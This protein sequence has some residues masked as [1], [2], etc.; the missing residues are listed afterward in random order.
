MASDTDEQNGKGIDRRRFLVAA[1]VA[2]IAAA[3]AG[4]GTASA[5]SNV[6]PGETL[7][8]NSKSGK[9]VAIVT[10]TQLNIG[11]PLARKFAQLNYNLVIADVLQGLPEELRKLGDGKVIVVPGLE[12]EGPNNE[13][14]PGS[15]QKVVDAAMNEFGGYD[16]V[17]I[18]T[19]VH[20]PAGNF[21]ETTKEG[22]FS[23]Y[24]QNYLAVL[25]AL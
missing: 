24:E 21:L 11:P 16:S 8:S 18:R 1:G 3:G 23:H 12:Q 13:S 20:S 2:G 6:A 7:K 17:F 14:K 4:V 10:D 22:M 25:Y 19:A 15:I 9:R 5:Q